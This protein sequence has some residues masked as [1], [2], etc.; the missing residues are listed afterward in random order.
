MIIDFHAHIFPDSVRN[1]RTP[2]LERDATF[3]H[4]YSD[5]EARLSSAEELVEKMDRD[6]IDIAVTLGMGWQ[7]HDFAVEANDYI[8]ESARAFPDRLVPFCTV[9]PALGDVAVAEI[10]RCADLGAR[11]IGEL[12]SYAQG[13]R[14]DDERVMAPIM[15]I[16]IARDLIVLTHSSEPVGHV[17]AGKGTVTPDELC[18]FIECSPR[19]RSSVPTGAEASPSTPSC[20]RSP[21]PC[22]TSTSTPP[23][24][25]SSTPPTSSPTPSTSSALIRS[26]SAPTTP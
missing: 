8:L 7:V 12:H 10:E 20:Q 4:L 26:S 9:N 13:Y 18:R 25:P 19:P 16:A 21:R 22:A 15:E 1:D 11:G 24:H 5:P 3:S 14:L 6:G 23:L 17:Y 2:Y